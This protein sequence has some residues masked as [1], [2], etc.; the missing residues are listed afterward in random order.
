[1]C[2]DNVSSFITTLHNVPLASDLCNGLF[3]IIM[4][5]IVVHTCLFHKGLYT[6]YY[7]DK[8]KN[9]VTLPH[10]AQRKNEF[11]V[12]TKERSKSNK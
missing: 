5:M 3:S 1:M 9:A 11:L 7:G 6:V 10:S 12:K 2:D 8:K 4:S